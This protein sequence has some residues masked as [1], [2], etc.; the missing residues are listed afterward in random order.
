M[1]FLHITQSITLQQNV[2]TRFSLIQLP[3]KFNGTHQSSMVFHW[4]QPNILKSSTSFGPCNHFSSFV[5]A[6]LTATRVC[7]ALNLLFR[8]PTVRALGYR[9]HLS[10]ILSGLQQK[11]KLP[12]QSHTSCVDIQSEWHPVGHYTYLGAIARS[13][14]GEPSSKAR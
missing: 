12:N 14:S 3:N 5:S 7:L 1:K 4:K 11:Q 13:N 6:P 8:I 2:L 10:T 9:Y